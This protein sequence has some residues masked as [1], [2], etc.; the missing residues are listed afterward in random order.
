VREVYALAL[1]FQGCLTLATDAD[2]RAVTYAT[3]DQAEDERVRRLGSSWAS[4]EVLTL[5]V[6][7]PEE[8][9][10]SEW[11]TCSCGT[12]PRCACAGD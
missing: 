5:P 11:Q 4:Y 7:E 1:R 6:L 8:P 2:G 9:D 10:R 3:R 12:L